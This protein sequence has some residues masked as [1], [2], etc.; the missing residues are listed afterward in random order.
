MPSL[1]TLKP[2][3]VIR[4]LERAGFY[5]HRQKG[6]HARL[7]HENNPSLRVTIPV[8]NKDIPKGTLANIIRQTGMTVDEFLSYL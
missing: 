7:L 1:P 5:I 2:N 3:E 8:H 4:A 6:S